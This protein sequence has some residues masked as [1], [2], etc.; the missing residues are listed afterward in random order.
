MRRPHQSDESTEVEFRVVEVR[1]RGGSAAVI[2]SLRMMAGAFSA[3]PK[4]LSPKGISA[5]VTE[6]E[7]DSP[8]EELNFGN[9]AAPEPMPTAEGSSRTQRPRAPK[10]PAV[11]PEILTGLEIK[12]GKP[13]FEEFFASI[14]EPDE[15]RVR[16]LAAAY[17]L[18]RHCAT[19]TTSITAQ[20]P[21]TIYRLMN[22]AVPKDAAVPLLDATRK[23]QWFTKDDKGWAISNVGESAIEKRILKRK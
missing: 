11:A 15:D 22:W 16:Y 1:V 5:A 13:T 9:D 21:F 18:K 3:K 10:K 23:N 7:N 6:R 20:H 8:Q 17:W 2:D 19:P 12:N 14:G 4:Q